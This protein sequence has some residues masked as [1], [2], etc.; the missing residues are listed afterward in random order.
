MKHGGV[1]SCYGST[2][3]IDVQIG[4]GLILKNI[5]FKGSTMGSFAE[6]KDA[7]A[8]IGKHK[9]VPV[10]HTVLEGLEKAEEGFAIM[11]AGGQFGK[12]SLVLRLT[13]IVANDTLYPR[14]LL[15]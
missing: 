7:V 9:I 4:M 15:L 3:G 13:P 2:T 12:V 14:L 6:F 5:E 11:K 10:V 8:F 1:I